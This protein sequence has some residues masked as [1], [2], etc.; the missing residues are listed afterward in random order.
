VN[1]LIQAFRNVDV[2]DPNGNIQMITVPWIPDPIDPISGPLHLRE[3][4]AQAVIAQLRGAS[5]P[6]EEQGP[7]PSIVRVRVFNGSG[8]AQAAQR[9]S[10]ALQQHGFATAGIGNNPSGNIAETQIR[11]RPGEKAKAS[12][13]QRYVGGVGELVRDSGI[14][15]ADVVLVLGRD[16]GG[17]TPP[18]GASTAPAGTTATTASPQPPATSGNGKREGPPPDP[19]QCS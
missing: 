10:D 5:A 13:V 17:V 16:F 14:V 9:T 19:T 7:S 18:P 4:D 3:P 1:K 12:V 6:V 11:Y 8:V 2:S 15:E